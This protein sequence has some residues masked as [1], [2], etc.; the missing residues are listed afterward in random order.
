M[1]RRFVL[2]R[3]MRVATWDPLAHLLEPMSVLALAL[4]IRNG[5]PG[6]WFANDIGYPSRGNVYSRRHARLERSITVPVNAMRDA[7]PHG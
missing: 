3:A 2:N 4:G 5:C 1:L 6:S 7:G